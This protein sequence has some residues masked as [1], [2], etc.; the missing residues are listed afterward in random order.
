[1]VAT[2][3]IVE[4]N[5]AGGTATSKTSGT[6]RFKTADNATVNSSN[7]ITIPASGSAW[8]YEKWLR[9]KIG[10]TGPSVEISNY[11]FYTDGA[12]GFGT[13][14]SLWAKAVTAFATPALGTASTGYADAFGKTSGS[15]LSLGAGPD[16]TINT[17]VGDHAVLLMEVASTATQGSLTGETITFTYDEI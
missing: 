3:D 17:E 14:V 2:V 13:G 6:V 7:P 16:S 5:T 9:L 15:P 11:N 4:K 12:D 1:M 8:S 10:A